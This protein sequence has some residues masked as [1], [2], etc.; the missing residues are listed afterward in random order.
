M[1]LSNI[2]FTHKQN[3]EGIFLTWTTIPNC[4]YILIRKKIG[5]PIDIYDGIVLYDGGNNSFFDS[6]INIDGIYYYRLFVFY[7][8]VNHLYVSDEKCVLKIISYKNAYEYANDIYKSLPVNIRNDDIS[9]K[10]NKPLYR[11]M[12]LFSFAFNKIDTY[13]NLIIEQTDI[14]K[15]DEAYISK[16][17]DWIGQFYDERFGSDLNRI[18]LKAVNDA[19]P[20]IG[21]IV[22][23][24]Y[25][26][27]RVF[28]AEIEISVVKDIDG[29]GYTNAIRLF[30]DED[31]K[32]LSDS[33]VAESI[34]KIIKNYC[35]LR[36]KFTLSN[37]LI[38][39]E[40]YERKV[41]SD[42]LIDKLIDSISD[43]SLLLF[44][45]VDNVLV[46]EVLNDSLVYSKNGILNKDTDLLSNNFMLNFNKIR[47][48]DLLDKFV[49]NTQYEEYENVYY[50]NID[51]IHNIN[52]EV[53]NSII[54]ESVYDNISDTK[55]DIDINDA[56]NKL[57]IGEIYFDNKVFVQ[58]DEYDVNITEQ[59]IDKTFV[60]SG[61][62]ELIGNYLDSSN[63]NIIRTRTLG[64]LNGFGLLSNDLFT[65]DTKY[66]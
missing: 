47:S 53:N 43:K 23:L 22:G 29:H 37:S 27:Q 42:V 31:S 13:S 8:Y 28:K 48:D 57:N 17:A 36:T 5:V 34:Y 44:S 62:T 19:E 30:F 61:S 52:S 21:T 11:F 58:S 15:C 40:E 49:F 56:Y 26:L 66:N 20:Y 39:F 18:L 14:D 41:Y 9:L 24:K 46:N 32:W 10:Q 33:K 51:I 3:G 54:S 12:R 6:T 65:N 64:V 59:V 38:S 2:E 63:D 35:A 45:D 7:D 50:D 16:H 55:Q 25:I 1:Q 60:N 4:R